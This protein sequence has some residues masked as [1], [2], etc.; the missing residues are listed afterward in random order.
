[1]LLSSGSG[2]GTTYSNQEGAERKLYQDTIVP[3][4]ENYEEQLNDFLGTAAFGVRVCYDYEYLPILQMDAKLRSQVRRELGLAVIYEFMNG[5][6]TWNE[7][8][9]AM[10]QD[11]VDGMDLYVYQ[12]PEEY[13][14]IFENKRNQTNSTNGTGYQGDTNG[15]TPGVEGSTNANNG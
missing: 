11:I 6:I 14:V 12:L 2:Q 1:V 10:D 5:L 3:E 8:K 7:M 9:K 4:A 15:Q 13:R